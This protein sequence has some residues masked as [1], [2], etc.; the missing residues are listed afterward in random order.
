MLKNYFILALRN[1]KRDFFY[2]SMNILGLT[3]GISSSLLLLMYVIDDLSYDRYHENH[4]NIYRIGTHITETD[5]AFSWSVCPYPM[6]PQVKE[7]FPQVKEFVRL[8]GSGATWYKYGDI[9]F[10][11]EDIVYAD[12]SVFEVFT[13]PLLLGDPESALKEPNTIVISESM[14]NKYFGDED[15]LGKIIEREGERSYEVTGVMKDVPRNSHIRFDA[16]LSGSS[17]PADF[18]SWGNY[19]VFT[20]VELQDGFSGEQL[21]ELLP[22]IYEKYQA[23][24]F[25]NIGITM[26]YESMPITK[27]HLHSTFEGEP[28]P[29][30]NMTYIYIFSAVIVLMLII[31]SINYMNLA[32]ARSVRRAREVGIRKVVGSGKGNLIGQFLTES[33]S[34]AII[35]MIISFLVVFMLIPFFNSIS[36]RDL[37]VNF[38][39]RPGII[40]SLVGMTALVGIVGGSYPAFYLSSFNPIRVFESYVQYW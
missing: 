30:G 32:I 25:K 19:G 29:V 3:I 4:E 1:L 7:D 24:I 35:A 12:S 9:Q 10:V 2:N 8:T 14:A 38:L 28:V 5:D 16:M 11:E 39:F 40:A 18:G 20:Y 21:D 26:E 17:L 13:Y 36:G 31:A 33:T 22:E 23:E 27:I 6:A 37:E 15:P 34:H